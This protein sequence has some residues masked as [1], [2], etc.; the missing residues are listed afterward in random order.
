MEHDTLEVSPEFIDENKNLCKS[1]QNKPGPRSK[2]LR[3]SRRHEVYRLH[4]E[5]GYPAV[6]I[7]DMMKI[8]RNTINSDI[9][10]WYSKLAS[11]FVDRPFHAEME[12]YQ[13]RL[14][15]QRTRLVEDL[16]H[17]KDDLESRLSIE[18]IILE[19]DSRLNSSIFKIYT[20][21]MTTT[22]IAT[23]LV[24]STLEKTKQNSRYYSLSEL[25]PISKDRREAINK[26]L[27]GK[28]G[29][30]KTEKNE[31]TENETR[32]PTKQEREEFVV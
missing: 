30:V 17:Y 26:I 16:D 25:I 20:I 28:Y 21:G 7:A 22:N 4:F 1:M 31:T 32:R 9:K 18:K 11:R 8:N 2:K 29:L 12:R 3:F 19:I 24:N 5:L 27:S 15:I 14:E 10:Y 13:I 6:K 23:G